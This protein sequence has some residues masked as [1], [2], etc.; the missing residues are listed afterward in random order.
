MSAA[1]DVGCSAS[2]TVGELVAAALAQLGQVEYARDSRAGLG[3]VWKELARFAGQAG[4]EA[5]SVR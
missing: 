2:T 1:R 4:E 5:F 3:R